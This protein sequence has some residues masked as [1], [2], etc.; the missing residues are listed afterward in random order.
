MK[1]ESQPSASRSLRVQPA[2]TAAAVLFPS[3][4]SLLFL[5]SARLTLV[6]FRFRSSTA[7]VAEW[8]PS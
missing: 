2:A 8:Y 1:G 7:A 6:Q 3:L 4:P 5:T